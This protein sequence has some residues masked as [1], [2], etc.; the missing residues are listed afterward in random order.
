V[1]DVK[2]LLVFYE[3]FFGYLLPDGSVD[4]SDLEAKMKSR[5]CDPWYHVYR[6]TQLPPGPWGREYIGN[7]SEPWDAT[8]FIWSDLLELA[9]SRC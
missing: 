9:R 4:T 2:G 6:S 8:R 3:E 7:E 1:I 5:L